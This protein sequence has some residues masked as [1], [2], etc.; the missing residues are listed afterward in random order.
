MRLTV[1]T[2]VLCALCVM[3]EESG[4]IYVK[5]GQFDFLEIDRVSVNQALHRLKNKGYVIQ[6]KCYQPYYRITSLGFKFLKE[7]YDNIY[8]LSLLFKAVIIMLQNQ[9]EDAPYYEENFIS[10]E[11][12]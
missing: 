6:L 1:E 12:I 9:N 2:Q 8:T 4:L 10:L 11:E 5:E 7:N 3:Q